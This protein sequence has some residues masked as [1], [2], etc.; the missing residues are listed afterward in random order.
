M[1][2]FDRVRPHIVGEGRSGGIL[3]LA[4]IGLLLLFSG[5]FVVSIVDVGYSLGWIAVAFG[6]AIA[7]GAVKAGLLPTIGSV[8]LFALWWFIFPPLVGY[9]TGDWETSSRYTSPRMLGYGY[10]SAYHELRGGI[11]RGGST[12]LLFAIFV[13]TV[14]YVAGTAVSRYRSNSN[15]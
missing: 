5:G 2:G 10:E 11:E 12:G 3:V 9:L 13:G 8:W 15:R 14:G 4:V 1:S 7:A 6:I